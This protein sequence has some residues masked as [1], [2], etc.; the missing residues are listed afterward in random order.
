M[1]KKWIF[2][3]GALVCLIAAGW[4]YYQYQKPRA[5]AAHATAAYT[6]TAELLYNEYST[7]EAAADKKYGN[8]ILAVQ[9]KV[10]DVQTSAH[11]TNI[12]LA[13]GAAGG[14]NCSLEAGGKP[15]ATLGET[16]SVKGRCTG[17]LMDVSLVDA[18]RINN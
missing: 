6:V 12:L 9:G 3:A 16:I 15:T 2:F 18:V 13:A 8:K 11:G 17:F 10:T 7:N 4:G 5:G 1:Q 14:V